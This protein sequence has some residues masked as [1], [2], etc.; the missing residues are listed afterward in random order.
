MFTSSFV[1]RSVIATAQRQTVSE[2]FALIN[3]FNPR[4]NPQGRGSQ[5]G[6]RGPPALLLQVE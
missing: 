6:F 1:A 2:N 4:R 3:S 5:T